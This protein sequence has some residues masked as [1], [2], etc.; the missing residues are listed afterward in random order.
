[1]QLVTGQ[2]KYSQHA[3]IISQN[4]P[5]ISGLWVT[6]GHTQGLFVHDVED[7]LLGMFYELINLN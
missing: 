3:L 5:S 6:A 1:M 2:H 4:N 7:G